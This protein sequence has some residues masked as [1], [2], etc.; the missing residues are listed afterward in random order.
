MEKMDLSLIH[1]LTSIASQNNRFLFHEN[2][3]LV[4]AL[5]WKKIATYGSIEQVV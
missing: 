1:V 4:K 3:I 2:V 5:L